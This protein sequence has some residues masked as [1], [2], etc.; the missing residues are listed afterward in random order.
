LADI[1]TLATYLTSYTPSQLIPHR[2]ADA[3]Q[4]YDEL[5]ETVIMSSSLFTHH[6]Q[7]DLSS[8][9]GALKWLLDDYIKRA[10]EQKEE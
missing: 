2:W 1:D 6:E 9:M 5:Y 7:A 8:K 3:M 4:D 10:A